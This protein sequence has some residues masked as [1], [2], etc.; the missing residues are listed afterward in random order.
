MPLSQN[1]YSAN[2]PELM[3]SVKI[4]S[5]QVSLRVRQGP[6][7]DLLILVAELFDKYVQDIDTAVGHM[8]PDDWGYAE[9]PIRGSTTTLSNHSSGTA[10]D[11][12]A[13][14]WSLGSNPSVNLNKTQID[15]I[16]EILL[17]CDGVV[18]WGGD[19]TGRKDP[20]HFEINDGKSEAQCAQAILKLKAKY[21]SGKGENPFMALTDNQQT[22]LYNMVVVLFAQ[23]TGDTDQA[24]PDGYGWPN[25]RWDDKAHTPLTMIDY[26]RDDDRELKSG[27][28]LEGRPVDPAIKDTVVGHILSL[29]AEVAQLRESLAE[30]EAKR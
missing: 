24:G 15:K 26:L 23:V 7:G 14:R 5:S 10:I 3:H 1:G 22:D 28:T 30:A 8:V 27:F 25:W 21:F 11:L 16:H 4:P 9:R 17:T 29:R 13:T 19:Y 6:T 12:N 18:R 20:M 2:K